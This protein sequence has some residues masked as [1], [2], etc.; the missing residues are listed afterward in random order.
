MFGHSFFIFALY[1]QTSELII[2]QTGRRTSNMNF[3]KRAFLSVKARPGKSFL[4][5]FIFSIICVLVL[6]GLTIQSAAKK[7]SEQARQQLGADVTLQVDM[8]KIRAQQEGNGERR[9][10]Q[11]VPI[12]IESA[13]ELLSS[14]EL[15]GFNFYSST[16]GLASDFEPIENEKSETENTEENAEGRMPGREM[17]FGDVSIQGVAFTDSVSDFTKGTSTLVEGKHITKEDLGTNVTMI[18]KTLAE[19]ND[20]KLG[21]KV[22]VASPNDETVTFELEIVG[23]YETSSTG[24]EQ[25]MNFT[26]LNPYNRLY[27]PYTLTTSLKG[28]DFEGTIDSA[29]YYLNDP[30]NIQEFINFATDNSSIDFDTYKL[31]ANDQLYKQ[32]VGPIQ[33]VSSFS[34]NV[35]YLVTIA[36]A[37]I[38]G[39]IVMMSIRDRKYEMGVLLAI[40]E[41]KWKLIGQFIT[42]IL[43]VA[44]IALGIA[45]ISGNLVANKMGEQLL[46]QEIQQ[47]EESNTP[48]SFFGGRGMSFRMGGGMQSNPQQ[49]EP[50]DELSIDVTAQDIG[51]LSA[52]G[53]LIALISTLIPSLSVLRLQPKTILSKQD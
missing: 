4:Q 20:L 5:V 33:N 46:N 44:V 51:M 35:V 48:E 11:A 42:E 23:I 10:F 34:N 12:P 47:T 2:S 36:G 1:S 18:E 24:S 53:F 14:K 15:K 29:I 9:R 26:A 37:I 3:F 17:M 16:M 30:A 32:M 31:D 41:K 13:E 22:T 49:A 43:V 45:T 19:E 8:E 21:D 52:I 39:L 28:T 27:V 6:S 38:L 25:A 40:G 7:S 50:V